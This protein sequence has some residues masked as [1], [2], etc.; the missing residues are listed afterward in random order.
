MC[1]APTVL[2]SNL[3]GSAWEAARSIIAHSASS[4]RASPLYALCPTPPPLARATVI[5]SAVMERKFPLGG[6]LGKVALP[7]SVIAGE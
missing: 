6:H 3:A 5:F 7:G 1:D 4:V 2:D